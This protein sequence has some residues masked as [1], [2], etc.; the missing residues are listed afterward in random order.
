MEASA[1]FQFWHVRLNKNR[2]TVMDLDGGQD[3]IVHV[4][5]ACLGPNAVEGR[6]VV[7]MKT[8][9]YKG[10][11]CTLTYGGQENVTLDLPLS[12][13]QK[14]VLQAEGPNN[15]YLSGY[16]QPLLDEP[17]LT[18]NGAPS[19][20]AVTFTPLSKSDGEGSDESAKVGT[21]RPLEDSAEPQL[22]KKEKKRRKKLQKQAEQKAA[23]EA[24]AAEAKAAAAAA[25]ANAEKE[26]PEEEDSSGDEEEEDEP[27]KKAS[28][29]TP[30]TPAK[31]PQEKKKAP[32]SKKKPAKEKD[33]KKKKNWIKKKKGVEIRDLK[34]GNGAA[35]KWNQ[36]VTVKYVGTLEDKTVFDQDLK[37]GFTFTI[38][39]DVVKG[40]SIGMVG[41]KVGG[42]RRIKVPP[43]V[44]YGNKAQGDKIP[45]DSTLIFTVQRMA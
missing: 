44:G 42:K 10:P 14:V 45:A 36:E 30:V 5:G 28:P 31:K 41:L 27:E 15:A 6:T 7:T 26:E 20:N 8:E 39:K 23:A 18:A 43:A 2:S 24:K 34:D 17:E 21:K 3:Y 29:P 40:L 35:A 11:I 4:S 19:A 37:E 22:S 32:E 9:K 13:D 33:G 12:G 25:A 16:L 1:G 38:G